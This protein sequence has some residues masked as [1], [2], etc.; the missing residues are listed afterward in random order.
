MIPQPNV[1]QKS[2]SFCKAE[3]ELLQTHGTD[4][5]GHWYCKCPNRDKEQDE[6]LKKKH[7]FRLVT[8]DP[9]EAKAIKQIL[10]VSHIFKNGDFVFVQNYTSLHETRPPINT[11]IRPITRK[12]RISFMQMPIFGQTITID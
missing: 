6:I 9:H 7:H 8:T 11:W 1:A 5:I 4:T 10:P 3:A 12:Y 2:C